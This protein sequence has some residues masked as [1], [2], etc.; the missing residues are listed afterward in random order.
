LDKCPTEEYGLPA[1]IFFAEAEPIPANPSVLFLSLHSD[2][3]SETYRKETN[4]LR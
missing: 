2:R 3:L 4:Q 1:I